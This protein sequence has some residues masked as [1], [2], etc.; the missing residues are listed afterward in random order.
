MALCAGALLILLLAR[1]PR[2]HAEAAPDVLRIGAAELDLGASKEQARGALSTLKLFIK[3]ET[4]FDSDIVRFKTWRE[5]GEKMANKEYPLGVFQGHEFAWVQAEHANLKPLVLA[6]KG[7][8]FQTAYIVTRKDDPAKEFKDMKGF[9]LGLPAASRGFPAFFVDRQCKA[10]GQP[11]DKFFSKITNPANVEDAVDDVVDAV[12]QAAVVDQA[13][14]EAYKRR[15]PGRFRQ[16]KE[17]VKSEPVPPAV[18]A[19]T[20]GALDQATLDR[21]RNG[22]RKA[23]QQE[24]GQTLLTLFR[25]TGFDPVPADFDKV[26]ESTRKVYPPEEAKK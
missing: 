7:S 19:Y 12:V 6:V 23:G 4:G 10:Q 11:M 13:G 2:L 8:R 22:L 15:K 18:I 21:F 25:L 14:L 3:E 17:V 5:L 20:E 9:T 24:R 1:D 26:L 16:I